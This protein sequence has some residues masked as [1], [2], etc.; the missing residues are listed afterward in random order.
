[1]VKMTKLDFGKDEFSLAKNATQY[2]LRFIKSKKYLYLH[3]VRL[4]DLTKYICWNGTLTRRL[5]WPTIFFIM[6]VS[7]YDQILSYYCELSIIY[8][9][10]I[11]HCS[12]S[13]R[14]PFEFDVY[15]NFKPN[16]FY[17]VILE[18]TFIIFNENFTT[19]MGSFAF[20]NF[21]N[22]SDHWL[23]FFNENFL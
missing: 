20:K 14:H 5:S 9:N 7:L 1:M 8:N 22:L 10:S 21:F 4:K 2:S 23:T 11:N 17:F 18:T 13:S 3:G 19:K 16:Y 15:H 6:L 12:K